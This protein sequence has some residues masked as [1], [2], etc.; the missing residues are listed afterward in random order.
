MK[1]YRR[2]EVHADSGRLTIF[3]GEWQLAAFNQLAQRSET[4]LSTSHEACDAVE[5]GSAE[6]QLIIL[7]LIRSLQLR[8]S[9]E[10]LASIRSDL[11]APQLTAADG[12][13]QSSPHEKQKEN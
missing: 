7:E 10:T 11:T 6:G 12:S 8:L 2:I 1:K 3:S 13:R 9:P 4:E 5:P